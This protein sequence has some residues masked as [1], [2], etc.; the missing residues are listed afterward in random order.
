[1][2]NFFKFILGETVSV[3]ERNRLRRALSDIFLMLPFSVFIIIPGAE[4]LIPVYV[5]IFPSAMPKAFES[6]NQKQQRN[7]L[8]KCSNLCKPKGF[9]SNQ[10]KA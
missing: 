8:E 7:D 6:L 4:L 9:F 3:I 1:M 10:L 2:L 5:K